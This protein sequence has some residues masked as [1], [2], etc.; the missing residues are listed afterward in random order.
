MHIGICIASDDEEVHIRVV[1][2]LKAPDP[3]RV[4][5]RSKHTR[6]CL[7]RETKCEE[8]AQPAHR[9]R[10]AAHAAQTRHSPPRASAALSERPQLSVS[11]LDFCEVATQT[12][13]QLLKWLLNTKRLARRLKDSNSQ[14][15][16][17]AQRLRL[18][19]TSL[20]LNPQIEITTL[21]PEMQLREELV[22]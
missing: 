12:T 18:K 8:E 13:P 21:H 9:S 14:L 4:G 19:K 17:S 10:L 1:V 5:R 16:D 7:R 22:R 2:Q 15:S 11:L 6:F 3:P 20:D